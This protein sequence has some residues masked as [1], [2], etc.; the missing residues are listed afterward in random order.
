[1]KT[2]LYVSLLILMASASPAEAEPA[3]FLN[4]FG[5][6]ATAYVN[7]SFL[8]LGTIADGFVADIIPKETA[9]DFVGNMQK[10]LRVVRSKLKAVSRQP[11]AIMDKQLIKRLDE[12][13]ACMDQLAWTL[14]QYIQEKTV[15]S[16]KRFEEQRNTCLQRL[17]SVRQFYATLPPSDE[18]PEPLSTR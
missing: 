11:I 10:R 7:D 13:Y 4:A 12:A 18:F 6:T 14:L 15:D 5:E 2:L 9:A 1:M 17:E 16:A 3:I 8:L